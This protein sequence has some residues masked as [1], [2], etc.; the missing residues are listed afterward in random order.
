MRKWYDIQRDLLVMP[1]SPLEF[2]LSIALLSHR[3]WQTGECKPG[4]PMLAR[5]VGGADVDDVAA[6]LD[7]LESDG[8]IR[9]SYR[10][11]KP[12]A[13]REWKTTV[14]AFGDRLERPEPSTNGHAIAV[15]APEPVE[16][17]PHQYHDL[18][19]MPPPT[20]T[21]TTTEPDDM[22]F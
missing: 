5:E 15:A 3:D 4:I 17:N 1:L 12:D 7:T 16:R 6:A 14:Y 18:V 10:H 8:V 21:P 19:P 13:V 9:R 11:N 2:K 20:P 22:P